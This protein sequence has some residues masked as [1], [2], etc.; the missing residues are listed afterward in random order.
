MS[1]KGMKARSANG[2]AADG[3][4]MSGS[5]FPEYRFMDYQFPQPQYLGAKYRFRSWIAGFLPK[6]VNIVV[7]P[8]GG[9]QSMSYYFKQMGMCVHTNDLMS[10]SNQ[11]GKALVENREEILDRDDMSLLLSPNPDVKSFDLMQTLFTGVFFLEEDAAFIDA[12]RGNIE[13]LRSPYKR[14]LA[15]AVMNRALTRK[16]TM[17]HFAHTQALSYAADPERVKRNR[18]L[19][20]PVRDI[21]TE[22]VPKYNSAV[23][24][25]GLPCT[26]RRGDAVDFV[27]GVKSADAVY[28]DPPYGNSHS[29]Y[30]Q[31]YHLLETYVEYWKDKTFVNGVKR[32]EPQRKTAFAQKSTITG[33]LQALFESA[34]RIPY[35]LLSYNDRSFP[36]IS[37]LSDMVA[38]FRKVRVER[39]VYAESRGGKGSVAGSSEILIIGEPR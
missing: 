33:A 26:S 31:F 7:D 4:V 25:N 6:G 8:F 14:A 39:R 18:S 9:S 36:D 29:D 12:V 19:V 22:L 20:R 32:Y 2:H 34:C 15:M 13:R 24:D 30:Q 17:G 5:L 10:F 16:V 1:E 37:T 21:F 38:R 11:I 35:W 28:F 27:A 3:V 23:F